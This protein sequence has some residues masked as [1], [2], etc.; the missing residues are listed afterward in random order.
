MQITK[1]VFGHYQDQ[2]IDRYT[3]TNQA[4]NLI[5][6]ITLGATWQG[7]EVNGRP[8]TVHFNDVEHYAGPAN[9]CLCKSVGRVAGR[10]TNATATIDGKTVHFDANENGNTLH[11]GDHGFANLIWNAE[12]SV[13][14]HDASVK[15]TRHIPRSEDNF[16][17]DLDASI[18]FT[19]NDDNE[20]SVTFTGNTSATTLFN[21]TNHAYF[22]LTDGQKDLTNQ[23]LQ[24]N[25]SK[26]L[27]LNDEKLPTGQKISV[28]QTGYDFTKPTDIPSALKKIKEETGKTEID[29]A[30][31]VT[32]SATTPI[33]ILSDRGSNRHVA[34]YSDRNGLVVYTANPLDDS[35]PY[36]ALATEAQMLPDAINHDGFGDITLTPGTPKQ[37]T[38]RYKYFEE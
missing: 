3:I 37:Y 28:E 17:G 18:T 4:G 9:Y 16:P 21:P 38:I 6:V 14:E 35:K 19:F 12:K 10:L 15:F 24:I 27:E 30:F 34:I 5:R 26:R 22:N 31:E 23:Q 1:D 7:F 36:N 20:V 11:G 32:A 8:L 33:A 2:D 13:N 29:D 25:G